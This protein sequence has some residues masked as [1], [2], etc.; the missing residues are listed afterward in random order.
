[1]RP[2]ADSPGVGLGLPIVTSLAASFEISDGPA[3]G[4]EVRMG[5]RLPG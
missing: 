5:F 1:M 3:G 2:R 4:T